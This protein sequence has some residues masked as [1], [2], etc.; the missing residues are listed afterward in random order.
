[1]VKIYQI[2]GKDLARTP[3][4]IGEH[5]FGPYQFAHSTVAICAHE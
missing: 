3:G 2:T 5:I 1:M 4:W